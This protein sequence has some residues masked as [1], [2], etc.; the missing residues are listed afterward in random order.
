MSIAVL[1]PQP[2]IPVTDERLNYPLDA[3][4]V[5][6]AKINDYNDLLEDIFHR[7]LELAKLKASLIDMKVEIVEEAQTL[8]TTGNVI[9][10]SSLRGGEP[11]DA[12]KSDSSSGEDGESDAGAS[13]PASGSEEGAAKKGALKKRRGSKGKSKGKGRDAT[14]TEERGASWDYNLNVA[15]G[16]RRGRLEDD[17]EDQ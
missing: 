14:R 3:D 12:S 11:T 1:A 7:E 4:K 16:A 13:G 5:H 10:P 15:G 9:L 8:D 6:K 17:A 2:I